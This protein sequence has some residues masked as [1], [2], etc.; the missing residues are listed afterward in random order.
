MKATRAPSTRAIRLILMGLAL[1][2]V[3]PG[4]VL[5]LVSA[6][7][8][9]SRQVFFMLTPLARL[10]WAL[11]AGAGL[12]V[13]LLREGLVR[14]IPSWKEALDAQNRRRVRHPQWLRLGLWWDLLVGAI[15]FGIL[16]FAPRDILMSW[17]TPTDGAQASQ[18][19]AGTVLVLFVLVVAVIA[20]AP[21]VILRLFDR[22]R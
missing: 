1:L 9:D 14:L 11:L 3:L 15:A 4:L 16:A 5:L 8:P 10:G 7:G 13:L 17:F 2:L 12:C 22:P 20:I 6:S 21:V 19:Y 18:G